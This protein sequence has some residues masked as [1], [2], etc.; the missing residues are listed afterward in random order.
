MAADLSKL[1]DEDLIALKSGDLSKVSDAGLLAL[2]GTVAEKSSIRSIYE[3]VTAPIETAKTLASGTASALAGGIIGLGQGAK[4][5]I[6][7]GMPAGDRVR[8]IQDA[9]TY[10]PKSDAGRMLTGA[11]AYPFEKL[12]QGADVA[13]GTVADATRSP[14]L[15]AIVNTLLQSAPQLLARGLKIPVNNLLIKSR[16]NAVSLGS[17]NSVNDS[18]LAAARSEGYVV[19]PSAADGGSFLG[20]RIEGIGG[21]AAVGQ[22]AA[23][24]NQ[25]ITNK[26][27]RREAGLA[28]NDP[29]TVTKLQ[30]ARDVLAAPYRE[31]E[32]LP[33]IPPKQ[34]STWNSPGTQ[35][36][37]MGKTPDTPKE[38][39]HQWKSNN[40]KIT[41]LWNDYKANHR[42]ET[43][44]QYRAAVKMQETIEGNIEAAATAAGRQDLVPKLQAARI[45]L[46]K[47]FNVERALNLGN[48]NV[49]A[50]VLG[51]LYDHGAKLTGGLETIAKFQQA[52]SPFAREGVHSPGISKLEGYG[53]LGLGAAGH[54]LAPG[55]GGIVA[56]AIPLVAPPLARSLMLSKVMQSP[57]NYD[58]GAGLKLADLLTRN[59]NA[60][61]MTPALGDLQR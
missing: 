36:P 11:I 29:I 44:D 3:H 26:I 57:R 10:Q 22:Q 54:F 21:K 31:V 51:R 23:V 13:G 27:A 8:Q 24:N 17:K 55:V 1:S 33:G 18:T 16:E 46:A 35:S 20:N 45:V 40:T 47:N 53:A 9:M 59:P 30:E 12:A 48:G 38:L 15:G 41:D 56:G 58:T 4:N 50:A 28:E 14:A 42:V 37:M 49:D 43:L 34:I 52:F 5:L 2:K 61:A 6:S 39:I 60:I 7:P 25:P 32:A 19:P